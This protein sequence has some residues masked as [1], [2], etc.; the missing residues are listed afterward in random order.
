MRRSRRWRLIRQ[1]RAIVNQLDPM[2]VGARD[3]RECLL[4]QIDG[5]RSEAELVLN[6][7][8]KS[9]RRQE[10]ALSSHNGR[11]ESSGDECAESAGRR[12]HA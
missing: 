3:L 11:D 10:V 6:R 9:V 5:Q 7:R 8:Q 2:G 4:I 1:A 12:W